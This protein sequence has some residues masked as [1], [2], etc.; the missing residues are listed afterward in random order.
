[1]P[2]AIVAGE[3]PRSSEAY[4]AALDAQELPIDHAIGQLA[5]GHGQDVAEGLSRDLHPVG[6]LFLV[7]SLQVG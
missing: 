7:Q 1:V 5:A 3:G 2:P 6:G 4:R